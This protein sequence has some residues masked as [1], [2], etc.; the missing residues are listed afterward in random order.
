MVGAR[1]GVGTGDDEAPIVSCDG[2]AKPLRVRARADQHEERIGIELLLGS[3]SNVL[4]R[5]AVELLGTVA[6]YD[7]CVEQTP[8]FGSASI[9]VARAPTAVS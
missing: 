7:S 1:G 5:D 6:G 2:A 3:G 8:T 9:Y 4:H